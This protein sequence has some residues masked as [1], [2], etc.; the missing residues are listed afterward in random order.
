MKDP[1]EAGSVEEATNVNITTMSTRQDSSE[2][3]PLLPSS[4]SINRDQSV[5]YRQVVLLC[6]TALVEPVAF[7]TIFPFV[8][9]MIHV[10]GGVPE[11]DVGFWAGLIESLF[12]LVQ[13]AVMVFYGRLIDRIGRKPVLVFT[14]TGLAIAAALFGMAQSLAQMIALRALAGLFGGSVV[15]TRVM[16]MENCTKETQARVFSWYMFSRHMGALLGPLIGELEANF[17]FY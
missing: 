11:Q 12:S 4:A 10:Q 1:D 14:L 16:I 13:M 3:D 9:E 6:F 5:Q 2:E 7:F 15:T 17:V 8:N